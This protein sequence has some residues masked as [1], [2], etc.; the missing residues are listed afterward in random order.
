[1]I[2]PPAKAGARCRSSPFVRRSPT[3]AAA[4]VKSADFRSGRLNRHDGKLWSPAVPRAARCMC[5][6]HP[7]RERKLTVRSDARTHRRTRWARPGR[8]FDHDQTWG[9]GD[10]SHRDD[11]ADACHRGR[12]PWDVH[13]LTF[14][15]RSEQDACRVTSSRRARGVTWAPACPAPAGTIGGGPACRCPASTLSTSA[16]VSAG[17]PKMVVFTETL[18]TYSPGGRP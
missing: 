3:V 12:L 17:N 8:G 11:A 14:F 13:V 1:M 5:R 6:R 16:S 15:A 9:N 2:C 7:S 10:P 18:T 4:R